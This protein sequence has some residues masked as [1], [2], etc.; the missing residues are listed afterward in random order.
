MSLK[1]LLNKKKETSATVPSPTLEETSSSSAEESRVTLPLKKK[2]KSVKKREQFKSEPLLDVETLDGAKKGVIRERKSGDVAGRGFQ[3]KNWASPQKRQYKISPEKLPVVWQPSNASIA[4]QRRLTDEQVRWQN[5]VVDNDF[6]TKPTP[7]VVKSNNRLGM[8]RYIFVSCL[9]ANK[10]GLLYYLIPLL[11]NV[12]LLMSNFWTMAFFEN[13]VF[14][15]ATL[16]SFIGAV[17]TLKDKLYSKFKKL[18]LVAIIAGFY[19]L[20]M[21]VYKTQFPQ[22]YVKIYLPFALKLTLIITGVYYFFRFYGLVLISYAQDLNADFGNVVQIYAGPP[23]VG[24]T[25]QMVQDGYVIA[26]LKWRELQNDF[27]M[28]HSREKEI[29]ARGN[30]KELLEYHEIKLAYNFYIMRPCIPCLWSNIPVQD[31][32]GAR[33]HEV[34]INHLKG[35]DRLPIYSVVLV[36]EIGAVLK[37][38]LGVTKD[39]PYDV[40]DM[41]RLGGHFLKWCVIGCEQDYN[42][43]YIDCR[44]VVGQNK[45]FLAQE[46]VCRPV[47]LIFLFRL[48]ELFLSETMDKKIKRKPRSAKILNRIKTFIKSIGFRRKIYTVVGNTQTAEMSNVKTVSGE[49]ITINSRR[50]IRYQP[51][52][53]NVVYD[54]RSYRECYPSYYDKTIKGRLHRFLTI[55]GL[56]FEYARQY[57]STTDKLEEKRLAVD[58][59]V[60]SL[61]SQEDNAQALIGLLKAINGAKSS[62]E[63]IEKIA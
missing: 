13:L 6:L 10:N 29:L 19:V 18:V 47:L 43:V 51:S 40:S 60:E 49:T 53:T 36:D 8:A 21:H 24:K 11:L 54:D 30:K 33:S 26:L 4:L 50:S 1:D 57:V 7:N 62:D 38:E 41:F 58:S 63:E 32:K 23:R 25:S 44:R 20:F 27:F 56:D 61:A 39:R 22:Y 52:L 59:N 15:C 14:A 35:V 12:L 48:L 9:I 3:L 5:N 45:M 16:I 28:W 34:T 17:K 46:W 31:K 55:D 37:A 42:N 2:E